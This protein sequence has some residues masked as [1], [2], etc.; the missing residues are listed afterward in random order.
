MICDPPSTNELPCFYSLTVSNSSCFSM[1]KYNTVSSLYYLL[2]EGRGSQ[3]L[4]QT[5]RLLTPS[6]PWDLILSVRSSLM[7]CLPGCQTPCHIATV[8]SLTLQDNTDSLPA[9]VPG[10]ARTPLT[11]LHTGTRA[12]TNTHTHTMLGPLLSCPSMLPG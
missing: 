5:D 8:S 6:S 10:Q 4:L 1:L 11:H 7:V 12:C 9:Y 3:G 2:D